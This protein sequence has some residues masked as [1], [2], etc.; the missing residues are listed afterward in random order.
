MASPL[1]DALRRTADAVAQ[2]QV[3]ESVI[4]LAAGS[5]EQMPEVPRLCAEVGALGQAVLDV[6]AAHAGPHPACA[7]CTTIRDA[8]AVGMGIVRAEADLQLKDML[9]D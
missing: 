3:P 4:A 1:D 8:L 5:L 9:G 2:Y 6:A 7:V